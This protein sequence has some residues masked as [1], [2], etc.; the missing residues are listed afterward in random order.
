MRVSIL[1]LRYCTIRYGLSFAGSDDR[2]AHGRRL[3]V[4]PEDAPEPILERK[5]KVGRHILVVHSTTE[6]PQINIANLHTGVWIR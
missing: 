6:A 5:G 2:P 1:S 4:D 3:A